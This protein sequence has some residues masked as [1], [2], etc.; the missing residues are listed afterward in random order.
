MKLVV[1]LGNPTAQYERTRHN[2]GFRVA[3]AFAGRFRI[4]LD[5]KKWNAVYGVGQVGGEKV[6]VLEPQTYMNLSG[7]SAGP[8]M[9]F[10]KIA[11]EDVVAVHD[12]LDLAFG[13]LQLKKGGGAAGHNGLKSL[14]AHLG[15]PDFVRLRVG[16]ARPPPRWDVADYV[17]SNFTGSEEA[18]LGDVVDKSVD[19]L[20]LFVRD[21]LLAAMN[22]VNR[23]A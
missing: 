3:E 15:G 10:F 13:R 11:P 20:E 22:V 8:A 2:V 1:G 18:E 19:A 7:E 9:R 21:G 14:T 12:E 5:G 23:K 16:I 4:P 6:V 17:L